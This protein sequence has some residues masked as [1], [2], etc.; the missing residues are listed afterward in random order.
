M[1]NLAVWIALLAVAIS[2][3]VVFVAQASSKPKDPAS[4]PGKTSAKKSS[5]GADSAILAG[6]V[7]SG[8]KSKTSDSWDSDGGDGGGG[9]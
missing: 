9:D 1:D 2:L 6:G 7:H 5:D 4:K 8:T 3:G